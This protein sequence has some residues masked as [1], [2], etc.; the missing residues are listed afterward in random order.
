MPQESI[1]LNDYDRSPTVNPVL[2][3]AAVS[4][5]I[6]YT[7]AVFAGTQRCTRPPCP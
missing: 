3:T 5:G 4:Y 6:L 2:Y 1:Y 7:A